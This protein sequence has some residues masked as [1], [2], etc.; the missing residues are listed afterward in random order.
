MATNTSPQHT[1]DSHYEI[2]GVGTEKGGK[3]APL[4]MTTDK[5]GREGEG[6]TC[7]RKLNATRFSN[8]AILGLPSSPFRIMFPFAPFSTVYDACSFCFCVCRFKFW[9][10]P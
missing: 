4:P 8:G 2:D 9:A 7:Y 5:G 10:S 6:V 3:F 1:R